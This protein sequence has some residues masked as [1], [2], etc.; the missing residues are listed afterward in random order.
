MP[1]SGEEALLRSTV[2][3]HPFKK[4][5]YAAVVAVDLDRVGLRLVAGTQEPESK[6]VPA[7]QR[8]GLVPAAGQPDL[9]AVFNGGFK[10]KH[11]GYGMGIGQDVFIPPKQDESCTVAL[12]AD[13]RVRI[14]TW[15]SLDH[16]GVV[17][18]RQTPP[19]LAREGERNPDLGNA[20]KS[21][22]WG[23]NAKGKQDIRRSAL[24][25]REDGRVLLFGL[26][27]WITPQELTHAMLEAGARD[28]AE[29]DI[30]WS[31]T[32][33]IMFARGDAGTPQVSGTLIPEIKHGPGEYVTRASSRDFFYLFQKHGGRSVFG[34]GTRQ[35]SAVDWMLCALM[36]KGRLR[37]ARVP[38]PS[39]SYPAR[40]RRV[41]RS[42]GSARA[43]RSS[44]DLI[45]Y[46]QIVR[47]YG[48]LSA[49]LATGGVD[50]AWIPPLLAAE[51]NK[52]GAVSML[53][54]VRRE[55]VGVYHSVLFT[56]SD[57]DVRTLSDMQGRSIGWVDRSSAG[58]Y[59]VPRLWLE[60]NGVD[61]ARCFS[62]ESFHHT[63]ANVARAVLRGEVDLGATYAVMEPRSRRIVDA[64]WF[65]V[66][67]AEE[68]GAVVLAQAGS[69]PADGIA[70][71]RRVPDETGELLKAALL[72]L[73]EEQRAEV[74]QVFRAERF[75]R[76]T[77]AYMASIE[78]LQSAL[79]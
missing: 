43:S 66:E 64:G 20:W 6:S 38:S 28:V 5:V 51:L 57:S 76:C 59:A 62:R 45:L 65:R 24:G 46:P 72:G 40:R 17:A 74:R 56:R 15:K 47:S 67:D 77:P 37:T 9:L 27:E 18:W 71:A 58:G 36:T 19:C 54:I 29:L 61:P 39:A 50:V 33:F 69:V 23:M 34:A 79:V 49:Q 63:H 30:N 78:R 13:G 75:E 44:W 32:R 52:S 10:A 8:S 22:R 26:G 11:G 70:V 55:S 35:A 53:A 7:E 2:H 41:S 1:L 68:V 21:R 3:P 25:T 73:S 4:F 14:G 16:S 60:H 42:S 48:A 12:Y 31:Y